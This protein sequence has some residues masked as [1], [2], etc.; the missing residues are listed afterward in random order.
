M[1]EVES[2]VSSSD[3]RRLDCI[4]W[5]A[6]AIVAIAVI[7][8]A[9]S[10]SFVIV[11][12]SFA[13]GAFVCVLLVLLSHFYRYIRKDEAL[14]EAL[15]GASQVIAFASVAAPLSY[16]AASVAFPLWD[17]EL[18]RWDQLLGFHWLAWLAFMNAAPT[19]HIITKIAYGSFAVQTTAI[20]IALGMTRRVI[21]MRLFVLALVATTIATITVSAFIPAQGVWGAWHLSL[22]DAPAI[23]PT[24]RDLPLGVFFGLRDGSYRL[25]VGDQAEGIISFPS[26]H[27]ALGLLFILALWPVRWLRWAGLTINLVMIAA[28]PIE[29]SHY[30][31]DVLAGLAIAALCWLAVKRKMVD[32]QEANAEVAVCAVTEPEA[33]FMA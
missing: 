2:A 10:S 22:S 12:S 33:P 23:V 7:F 24:T 11:W 21:H 26:L 19:L 20:V 30:L 32:R 8:T 5:S 31:T 3:I 9:M 1:H 14:A 27:A 16:I 29:G 17:T 4:I 15:I 25:L 18:T 13:K 6:I 28:T